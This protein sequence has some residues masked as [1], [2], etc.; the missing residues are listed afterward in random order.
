MS[1]TYAVYDSFGHI[2]E[3]LSLPDFYEAPSNSIEVTDGHMLDLEYYVDVES[4]ALVKKTT[5]DSSYVISGLVVL[6]S[7]LPPNSSVY[8]DDLEII[9][10]D[11]GV[12]IEF[13]VPGTYKIRIKPP[14]QYKTE[15]LEVTVG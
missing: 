13:D 9:S 12:E 15:V 2:K 1:K 4:K 5:I 6:L 7:S 8:V 14:Q 10:D 11:D 3:T